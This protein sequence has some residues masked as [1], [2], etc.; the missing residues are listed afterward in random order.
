MVRYP[1]LNN[2]T[3][4]HFVYIYEATNYVLLSLILGM[5]ICLAMFGNVLMPRTK[6]WGLKFEQ[7]I[8][9]ISYVNSKCIYDYNY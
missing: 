3:Y 2:D 4:K 8:L 9:M 5:L 6:I 7:P 1:I